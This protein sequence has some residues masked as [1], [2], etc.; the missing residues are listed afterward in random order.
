VVFIYVRSRIRTR[1]RVQCICRRTIMSIR[2]GMTYWVKG[3]IEALENLLDSPERDNT[4][5]FFK[6]NTYVFNY[7]FLAHFLLPFSRTFLLYLV[8]SFLLPIFLFLPVSPAFAPPTYSSNGHPTHYSRV[9]WHLNCVNFV[10]TSSIH[11]WVF[12]FFNIYLYCEIKSV[13]CWITMLSTSFHVSTACVS[14]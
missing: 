8:I 2:F 6:K 1:L 13:F 4:F 9:L 12:Q 7:F 14:S 10:T 5:L 11:C 3:D